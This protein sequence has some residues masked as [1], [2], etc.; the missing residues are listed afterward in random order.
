MHRILPRFQSWDQEQNFAVQVVIQEFKVS[1]TVQLLLKKEKKKSN[2]EIKVFSLVYN[3]SFNPVV[4][5]Y[6]CG[7][8]AND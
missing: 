6:K 3:N 2:S 8:K 5:D 1:K 4:Y 7:K